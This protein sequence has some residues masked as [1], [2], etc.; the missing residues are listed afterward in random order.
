MAKRYN[1]RRKKKNNSN[2]IFMIFL[3]LIIVVLLLFIFVSKLQSLDKNKIKDNWHIKDYTTDINSDNSTIDYSVEIPD[4]NNKIDNDWKINDELSIKWDIINFPYDTKLKA[5]YKIVYNNEDII[6]RSATLDLNNFRNKTILLTWN[7]IEFIGSDS[8]PVLLVKKIS[9]INDEKVDNNNDD[10]NWNK[11]KPEQTKNIYSGQGININ[12][13][14][15]ENLRINSDKGNIKIMSGSS[16]TWKAIVT[17]TPFKCSPEDYSKDC[18]S[19]KK[20]FKDF[21]F[22]YT[23]ND[24]NIKFWHMSEE[25]QRMA[26]GWLFGYKFKPSDND[27]FIAITNSFS[28]EDNTSLINDI[29][30]S[31]C[32]DISS[33]IKLTNIISVS[34]DEGN[35]KIVKGKDNKANDIIC[36]LSLDYE[37]GVLIGKLVDIHYEIANE[38]DTVS[39]KENNNTEIDNESGT[40]TE[41]T[42]KP[43]DGE[44]YLKYKS[45]GYGFEVWMPMSSKYEAPS[46]TKQ[47]FNVAGLDCKQVVKIARWKDWDLANPD[48]KVYYCETNVW[49]DTIKKVIGN[50][51]RIEKKEDNIFIIEYAEGYKEIADNLV[52]F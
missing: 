44:K 1:R 50:S 9:K 35:N 45:N 19:L 48:V 22:K 27:K 20:Y 16:L 17:I 8:T 10:D 51:Y 6:L 24:N 11:D 32:N 3:T 12:V 52:L 29:I 36:K 40:S 7:I 25:Q 47:P 42:N 4:N 41:S 23:T 28:F 39:I 5:N 43:K 18:A 30:L 2:N 14:N 46:V 15:W 13:S 21:N 26:F 37:N 33:Q 49:I 31:T 38:S 34:T